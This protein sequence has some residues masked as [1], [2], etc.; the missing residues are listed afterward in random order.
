M[1]QSD[2]ILAVLQGLP[3]LAEQVAEQLAQAAETC[4]IP[5]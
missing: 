4:H 2:G 3:G 1:P 5:L